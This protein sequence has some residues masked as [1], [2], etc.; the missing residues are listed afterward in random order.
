MAFSQ[1]N[2]YIYIYDYTYIYI[3]MYV[4]ILYICIHMYVYI[5]YTYIYIHMYVYIWYIYIYAYI[6]IYI[7]TYT[8]V[9]I[10]IDIHAWCYMEKRHLLRV[11]R[12]CELVWFFC[13]PKV[14]W[15]FSYTTDE[16]R[17]NRNSWKHTTGFESSQISQLS[18]F[19]RPD[20]CHAG[21]AK[22]NTCWSKKNGLRP[23]SASGGGIRNSGCFRPHN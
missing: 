9:Y 1:V 18:D 7:Y 15:C 13:F 2:I 4:Y 10:Y 21:S 22:L 5:W 11:W 17:C 19:L 23:A 12:G 20:A 14:N 6:C 3:H 8:Y 16:K